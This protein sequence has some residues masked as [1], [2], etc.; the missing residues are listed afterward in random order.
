M[1]TYELLISIYF[2]FIKLPNNVSTSKGACAYHYPYYTLKNNNINYALIER[3]LE[4]F[5]I[6]L[7]VIG[8]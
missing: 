5:V 2:Y 4:L 7:P 3:F 1:I 6:Y 8:T